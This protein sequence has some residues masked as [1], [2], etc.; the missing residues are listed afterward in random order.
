MLFAAFIA[1]G[2]PGS[3]ET[4][5]CDGKV[6]GTPLPD[7]EQTKGDCLVMV[8]DGA[9]SRK[10]VPLAADADDGN[11]CTADKC[12][13]VTVVHTPQAQVPCY[14]GTPGTEGFGVCKGGVL[15]CDSKGNPIG[16]CQGE[17]VPATEIC[18]NGADED[19]DGTLDDNADGCCGDGMVSASI[20]EECDD[21]AAEDD[22]DCSRACKVQRVLEVAPGYDF[23]CAR[24]SGDVVKCWGYSAMGQLGLGDKE[25]RGDDPG[26][27]GS[28]LPTVELGSEQRATAI[29]AGNEHVC[30]LLADGA[31]KCWGSNISGQLGL[32]N[33]INRGDTPDEMGNKL[34][35]VDLGSDQRATAIAVGF[36]HTCALLSGGAVKC[37]GANDF[38]QIALGAQLA[39]GDGPNEMGDMLPAVGLGTGQSAVAIAAGSQH[40]CALLANGSV[41]CWGYNE[42][43]ELGLGDTNHRGDD[44]AEMGNALPTVDLGSD[45]TVKAI[46]AGFRHTCALLANG[47]VKCWGLNGDGQLGLGDTQNRGDGPGEMGDALPAVDLGPNETAEA[48]VAGDFHTC[49][50]LAGGAVKCWGAGTLG[51]LGSN[52]TQPLGDEPNE[53]GSALPFVDVGP[54]QI[55]TAIAAGSY[56]TCALL[57][58]GTLKCW[59]NNFNGQLGLG[60][61]E[62]RGDQP[63]EMGAALPTVKL[64][65]DLW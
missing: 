43:G 18:S 19:C 48:I 39:R 60:D 42:Y 13:G 63:G 38:G 36:G 49:A 44:V 33:E 22:N 3:D 52:D 15:K 62:G 21:G 46:T 26:E 37:W 30:A 2:C 65:S 50:L 40:T 34:P 5:L 7:S 41:K 9:G 45:Q 57:S 24:L 28:A 4:P 11:P 17:I 31:V 10:V 58:T 53:M 6:D 51:S 55:V 54:G 59:G 56:H 32:G 12:E 14:S 29:S 8:C 35:P 23:T 47:S 20:G 1:G 16:R 61:M 27:M 25:A 64:F